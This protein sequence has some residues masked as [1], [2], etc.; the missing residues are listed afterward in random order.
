MTLEDKLHD[1]DMDNVDI[2][3]YED[4]R[5]VFLFCAF[6]T[7]RRQINDLLKNL[8][9]TFTVNELQAIQLCFCYGYIHSSFYIQLSNRLEDICFTKK[10]LKYLTK[11]DRIILYELLSDDDFPDNQSIKRYIRKTVIHFE[12]E[13]TSNKK[14]FI[15]N[16]LDDCITILPI[17]KYIC[18]TNILTKEMIIKIY[19]KHNNWGDLKC[20]YKGKEFIKL[21][22]SLDLID[23]VII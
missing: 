8:I 3:D 13:Y 1:I 17:L 4:D 11:H 19:E 5:E 21:I 22:N 6:Y 10:E 16:F 14:S 12:F 20:Y 15:Y 23:K 2:Y 18:N 7:F 9:N